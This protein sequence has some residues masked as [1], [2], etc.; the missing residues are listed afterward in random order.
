MQV[1]SRKLKR[2]MMMMSR[3]RKRRRVGRRRQ[4]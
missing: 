2:V 3:S 1:R 4:E